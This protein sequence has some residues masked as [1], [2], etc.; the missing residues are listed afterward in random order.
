MELAIFIV[1]FIVTMSAIYGVF[2]QVPMSM[3]DRKESPTDLSKSTTMADA[4]SFPGRD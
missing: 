2:A 1:G 4:I 3:A